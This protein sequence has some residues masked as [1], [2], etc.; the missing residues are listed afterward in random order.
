MVLLNGRHA[1]MQTLGVNCNP[2]W[3]GIISQTTR[4]CGSTGH[5]L[6]H[7]CESDVLKCK[8]LQ[9]VKYFKAVVTGACLSNRCYY[10]I[11]KAFPTSF[12]DFRLCY[13]WRSV[14]YCVYEPSIFN[15]NLV[16]VLTY[17]SEVDSIYWTITNKAAIFYAGLSLLW[18]VEAVPLKTSRRESYSYLGPYTFKSFL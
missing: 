5:K 6:G 1:T 4:W 8:W 16:F 3:S 2:N 18:A 13:N 9:F 11:T 15:F 12:S 10:G 14:F 17:L 7:V